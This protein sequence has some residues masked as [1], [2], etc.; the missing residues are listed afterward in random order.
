MPRW[1]AAKFLVAER[2]LMDEPAL[3]SPALAKSGLLQGTVCK[4]GGGG[5]PMLPVFPCRKLIDDGGWT[6][7]AKACAVMTRS[8]LQQPHQNDLNFAEANSASR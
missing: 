2:E 7:R 8:A 6:A 3:T 5:K 1:A 4:C